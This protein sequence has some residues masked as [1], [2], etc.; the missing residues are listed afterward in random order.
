[1]VSEKEFYQYPHYITFDEEESNYMFGR[2]NSYEHIFIPDDQLLFSD[3]LGS[4]LDESEYRIQERNRF[5]LCLS[6]ELIS[7]YSSYLH[8]SFP[9][10]NDEDYQM[11][12]EW[13]LERASKAVKPIIHNCIIKEKLIRSKTRDEFGEKLKIAIV[14]DKSID[15]SMKRALTTCLQEY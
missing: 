11:S 4:L 2:N 9:D 13:Q 1:M 5:S 14:L 7:L 15:L 3:V 8:K 10:Y 6:D 12:I